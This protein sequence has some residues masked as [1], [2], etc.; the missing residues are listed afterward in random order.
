MEGKA[1][2]P[3]QIAQISLSQANSKTSLQ[4]QPLLST[5]FTKRERSNRPLPLSFDGRQVWKDVLLHPPKQICG[6][7]WVYAAVGMMNNRYNI[8]QGFREVLSID[9]IF[10]CNTISTFL[11]ETIH[12][13][14]TT[15]KTVEELI[16]ST[17]TFAC[18]GDFLSSAIYFLHFRG[19]PTE[20]CGSDTDPL[21]NLYLPYYVPNDTIKYTK[22]CE[23]LY[24]PTEN[25]CAYTMVFN[26]VHCGRPIQFWTINPP[27]SFANVQVIM[28]DIQQHGP[29]ATTFNAYADFWS[30]FDPK[31]EIYTRQSDQFISGHSVLLVGWGVHDGTD[32]WIAQNSWGSNWG[33]GGYFRI[34]RGK[35][36]CDI[37]RNVI[38][39]TPYIWETPKVLVFNNLMRSCDFDLEA[40]KIMA[41]YFNQYQST[42][43]LEN[44]SNL[45]NYSFFNCTT[46]TAAC[47]GNMNTVRPNGYTL[48][49]DGNF[50]GVDLVSD[51]TR[52]SFFSPPPNT[53][54]WVLVHVY[55]I[56]V[57]ATILTAI[58]LVMWRRRRQ[59]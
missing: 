31:K 29:V 4:E 20:T 36:E 25:A 32:Y 30:S 14:K 46:S 51:G 34:V 13:R 18:N 55:G 19:L 59:R 49:L 24:Y 10:L 44:T 35:D 21:R 1:L 27:Y 54:A 28:E 6:S 38:A 16:T 3:A 53:R 12:K 26:G 58:L 2:S 37:E 22:T 39:A 43:G 45:D 40:F 8:M 15:R 5:F 48:F 47:N 57:V 56:I 52:Q 9:Y 11:D 17:T 33:D 41:K 42:F 23:S 7:C 50:P